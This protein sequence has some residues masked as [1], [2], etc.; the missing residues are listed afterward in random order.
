MSRLFPSVE[1]CPTVSRFALP[2]SSAVSEL[3]KALGQYLLYRAVL[4]ETEAD[5]E[6]FLAI[7]DIDHL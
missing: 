6:L 7:R 1:D 2:P 5:R 4:E 3:Q